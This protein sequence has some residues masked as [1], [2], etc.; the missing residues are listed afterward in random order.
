MIN[1]EP[2]KVIKTGT[3]RDSDNRKTGPMLQWWIMPVNSK[4][5]DA[6]QN[7]DDVAV[8]GDC[9]ARPANGGHCYLNHGWINGTFNA[10]YPVERAY[11][12][13]PDRLGAWGDPAAM[14]YDVVREHMGARWTGYTHQWR[15]CD[16]RFKDIVMASVDTP[17]EY[18]EATQAGWRTFRARQADD[19]IMDGEIT[20]PAS[21]EA[22]Q[23]VKCATCLLCAGM[24]KLTAKNITIIIH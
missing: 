20:C 16:A 6:V 14:P 17:Q 13:N 8:C 9:P 22:G 3:A 4:P 19:A 18:I 1:G 5:T 11:S 2:I 15:T 12:D 24:A 10:Q 23:R 7:G 21:K